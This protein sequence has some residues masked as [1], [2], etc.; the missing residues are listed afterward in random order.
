V[1]GRAWVGFYRP[2]RRDGSVAGVCW[3]LHLQIKKSNGRGHGRFLELRSTGKG[4]RRVTIRRGSRIQ[5]GARGEVVATF[6]VSPARLGR[7]QERREERGQVG[8]CKAGIRA[9]GTSPGSLDKLSTCKPIQLEC[10]PTRC[11]WKCPQENNI[12]ILDKHSKSI[13][14]RPKASGLLAG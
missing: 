10:L 9:S 14:M 4:P 2:G 13:L 11:L 7:G 12:C 5:W 8:A 1:L 3:P 6:L